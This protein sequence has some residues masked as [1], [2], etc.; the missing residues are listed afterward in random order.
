MTAT[1]S[2]EDLKEA[3]RENLEASGTMKTIKAK[4]RASIFRAIN[5]DVGVR[6][7]DFV[8]NYY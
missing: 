2:V 1:A 5:N 3:L 6:I 7:L 4:I 8:L